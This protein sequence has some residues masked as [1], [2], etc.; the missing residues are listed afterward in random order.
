VIAAL[1]RLCRLPIQKSARGALSELLPA[2][3]GERF[4]VVEGENL[5]ASYAP[6]FDWFARQHPLAEPERASGEENLADWEKRLAAVKWDAGVVARGRRIF[7]ERLCFRCHGNDGVGP[8]L[9]GIATRLSREDLF[10]A[11]LEPSR[12][13]SPAWQGKQ[14]RVR[15]GATYIGVPVYESPTATLIQ[16]GADATIRLTGDEI[17]SVES[18]RISLMPPGLLN[19]LEDGEIA[20]F[21]AFMK[22]LKK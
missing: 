7:E 17:L 3:T 21:Y 20:D 4:A 10:T 6:W 1:R 14:F 16:V 22:T 19:G 13:I 11:I 12:D 9:T 18:S 15:N 2:W 8:D 5:I